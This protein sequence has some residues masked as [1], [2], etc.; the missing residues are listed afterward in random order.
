MPA[1]QPPKPIRLNK[2]IADAGLGS[3]RKADQWIEEGLVKIN[4]RTSKKL[5]VMVVPAEG[6]NAATFG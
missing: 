3:R 4:D 2:F 5:G 6:L 1:D